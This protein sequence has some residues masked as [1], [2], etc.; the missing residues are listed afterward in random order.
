VAEAPRT[1]LESLAREASRATARRT[2]LW[3]TL[4]FATDPPNASVSGIDPEARTGFD[5]VIEI[6]SITTGDDGLVSLSYQP[7]DGQALPASL[8]RPTMV[9][10]DGTAEPCSL[11]PIGFN[12]WLNM[13]GLPQSQSAWVSNMSCDQAEAVTG[14]LTGAP[15]P[16]GC[17]PSPCSTSA[18]TNPTVSEN[19]LT[20][21]CSW[22]RSGSSDGS[23]NDNVSCN[24]GNESFSYSVRY[25]D[26]YIGSDDPDIDPTG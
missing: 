14:E 1:P 11:D 19:G 16:V 22:T 13:P 20:W 5:G 24:S 9:I 7:L 12:A 18:T 26:A 21:Q 25:S 23:D 15:N 2:G 10:D 17:A 6:T 4:G 8:E 3:N